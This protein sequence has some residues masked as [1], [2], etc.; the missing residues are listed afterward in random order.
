MLPSTNFTHAAIGCAHTLPPHAPH[1]S[2]SRLLTGRA[3]RDAIV[4]KMRGDGSMPAPARLTPG[5]GTA[6]EG[7]CGEEDAFLITCDQVVLHA[8]RILEK[9]ESEDEC[10]QFIR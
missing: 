4:T 1:T 2:P 3:K 8:G 5:S 9:P 7:G 10:R 6:S